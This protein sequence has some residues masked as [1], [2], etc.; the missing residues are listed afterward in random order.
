MNI[1][2]TGVPVS[3]GWH[4]VEIKLTLSTTTIDWKLDRASGSV[5]HA[6]LTRPNSIVLG[7]NFSNG[8]ADEP[9][10]SAWFDKVSVGPPEGVFNL[11]PLV[12]AGVDQ[13]IELPNAA[14]LDGTVS[15]DGLPNPPGGL[16]TTWSKLSGPGTVIFGNASAVDTTASFSE[17]GEYVLR[18]LVDDGELKRWDEV[19]VTVNSAAVAPAVTDAVSVKTQ[20]GND[21]SIDVFDPPAELAIHTNVTECRAGG[22]TQVV[23][24]FDGDIQQVTDTNADVALLPFGTVTG[25]RVDAAV[26]T[27]DMTGAAVATPLLIGFPGIAAAADIT[28]IATDQVCIRVLAG[29]VSN[30]GSVNVL[31]LVQVRNQL[32]QAAGAGNFRADVSGDGT[33]NVLD[34]VAIRNALNTSVASCP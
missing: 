9:D 19:T 7:Y 1:V 30:D 20:G 26:L 10:T 11:P 24:T 31:D 33:I 8:T 4:T 13:A 16:T 23:V 17:V 5:I 6:A 28:K 12:N 25:L 3:E 34:L 2:D 22:P 21:F 18:L 29:D 14:N 27:I 15:D 32:N